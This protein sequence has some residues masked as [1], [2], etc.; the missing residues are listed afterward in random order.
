MRSVYGAGNRYAAGK[1]GIAACSFSDVRVDLLL[2][3]G[4][5]GRFDI[6]DCLVR[7]IMEENWWRFFFLNAKLFFVNQDHYETV[8]GDEAAPWVKESTIKMV[9]SERN[10]LDPVI[11]SQRAEN[12]ER[13]NWSNKLEFILSCF[14]Y[15]VGLGTIWRFP[16]LWWARDFLFPAKIISS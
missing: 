15:A 16:Y 8:K 9:D 10:A 1:W 14:S 11:V 3:L 5:G 7:R 6:V 12:I 13:G 4:K 2:L